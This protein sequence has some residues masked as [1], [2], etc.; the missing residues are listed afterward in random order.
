MTKLEQ[1]LSRVE[2]AGDLLQQASMLKTKQAAEMV[3]Q[4][5]IKLFKE[6][7]STVNDQQHEIKQLQE[8]LK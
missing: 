3:G 1:Q 8:R 7:I 6:L 5:T 2:I 4:E